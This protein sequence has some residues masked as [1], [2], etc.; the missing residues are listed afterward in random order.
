LSDFATLLT[1]DL[2]PN[3]TSS[4]LATLLGFT[5]MPG[6][7]MSYNKL[8]IISGVF[9]IICILIIS[10]TA[11]LRESGSKVVEKIKESAKEAA[12]DVC[13]NDRPVFGKPTILRLYES[14]RHPIDDPS[15]TDASGKVHEVKEDAP[16]WREPLRSEILIVDIDTRVPNK[17]NELWN[18]DRL[19][20][21]TMKSEG[22]GGMVSAAFMNHFFYGS[23]QLAI[24][25]SS[26]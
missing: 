15:Y 7:I 25:T 9:V 3:S 26:L 20:W 24:F 4:L 2:S 12:N 10:T 22:D 6:P 1:T 11:G 13:N 8:A 17:K 23:Y 14:I 18:K 5:N 21:E 16:W 19:N